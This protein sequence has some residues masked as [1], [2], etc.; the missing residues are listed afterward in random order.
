MK[1]NIS[2]LGSEVKKIRKDLGYT[3]TDIAD[4]TGFTRG[5]VNKIER[6]EQRPPIDFLVKFAELC[7]ISLDQL[8][9]LK[10]K[11]PLISDTLKILSELK[12]SSDKGKKETLANSI[13]E[14]IQKLESENEELKKDIRDLIRKF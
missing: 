1:Q 4:Y 7:E 5:S 8:T 2:L 3:Q 13:L 10:K 11:T 6:N 9:G 12:K 14:I